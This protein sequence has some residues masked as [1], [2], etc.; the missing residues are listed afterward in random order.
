MDLKLIIIN[1]TLKSMY[2][3]QKLKKI[4]KNCF[5]NTLYL[6]DV[7]NNTYKK[8]VCKPISGCVM[9]VNKNNTLINI[10]HNWCEFNGNI[11]DPSYDVNSITYKKTYYKTIKEVFENVIGMSQE[12]KIFIIKEVSNFNLM[13]IKC[14][15][16]KTA[17]PRSY[18]KL[19]D[20]V[21]TDLKNKKIKTAK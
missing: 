8:N 6:T 9:Y 13:Y 11:I 4:K 14:M 1:E 17:T 18:A 5:T 19:Q 7:I 12:E 3:Y 16:D 15:K 21:M 10:C 20:F 2:K